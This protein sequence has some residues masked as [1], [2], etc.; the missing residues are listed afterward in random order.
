MVCNLGSVRTAQGR[1]AEAVACFR[2]ALELKPDYPGRTTTWESLREL[3]EL[4]EAV[5]CYRRALELKPDSAEAHNNLGIALQDQGQFAEAVACYRRALELKPDYAEAHNNLGIALGDQGKLDEAIACY[6]RALELKPDYRRGAQQPPVHAA[7]SRRRDPGRAG[8]GP[9]RVRAHACRAACGRLAAATKR[10]R[11]RSAALRLGFVSP[12]FGRHPGRY[13]LIRR[14]ENLDRGQC[15]A[16]C[17]CDRLIHDDLTARFQAA[18]ALWRDVVGLSDEQLAEQIRADR[19]DILFD[20]A[21]HTAHNRLLVVRPQAGPHPDHLDR[22]RRD[23]GPGG[24]GLHPG[25]PLHDPRRQPSRIIAS[26]CC[27]CPTATSATIRRPGAAGAGPLPALQTATSPSAAST[28]W[29]RSRRR[30]SASGRRSC[31]ACRNRG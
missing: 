16:V 30:W 14:L 7:V 6:R 5:A 12:D 17:Y 19:I 26:G 23:D 11:S 22:L 15:E 10:P 24:D 31:A 21:G 9:C 2:R 20:L 25:R 18:A 8:R 28:T 27:G 1:F 13:F 4:V 29:P 3:G